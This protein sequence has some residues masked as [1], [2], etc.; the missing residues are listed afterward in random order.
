MAA[1]TAASTSRSPAELM[2]QAVGPPGGRAD[3]SGG[4]RGRIV[5]VTVEDLVG[6]RCNGQAVKVRRRLGC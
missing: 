5:E 1:L 2:R 4:A 3:G 6:L